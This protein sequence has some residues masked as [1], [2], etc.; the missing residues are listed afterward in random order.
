MVKEVELSEK[1]QKKIKES[2]D[3]LESGE[4][5]VFSNIEDLI[6]ELNSADVPLRMP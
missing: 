2:L 3:A 6:E 1:G 5:K 4:Y